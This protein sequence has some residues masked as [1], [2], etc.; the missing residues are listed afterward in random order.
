MRSRFLRERPHT[1]PWLALVVAVV[2][3]SVTLVGLGISA[4]ASPDEQA[5]ASVREAVL[6]AADRCQAVEGAY[7]PSVDYLVEHY[8][9]RVNEQDF[10]VGYEW[11]ASNVPPTVSVRPRGTL[12]GAVS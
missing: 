3:V 5:A 11:F 6:L 12:V 2:A 4:T 7:P 9:L 8:G 1:G 10:R